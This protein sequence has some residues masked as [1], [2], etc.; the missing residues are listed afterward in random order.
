[1]LTGLQTQLAWKR[2]QFAWWA[3]LFFFFLPVK[4]LSI[5]YFCNFLFEKYCKPVSWLPC[6]IWMIFEWFHYY[7]QINQNHTPFSQQYWL[8]TAG[9]TLT[10]A[11]FK[12]FLLCSSAVNSVISYTSVWWKNTS[13]TLHISLCSSCAVAMVHSAITFYVPAQALLLIFSTCY[14]ISCTHACSHYPL[15]F[16]LVKLPQLGEFACGVK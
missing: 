2:W 8:V 11:L 13:F 1:M 15:I 6:S 14:F 10:V 9:V 3:L 16:F 5:M 7:S 12:Q 4:N